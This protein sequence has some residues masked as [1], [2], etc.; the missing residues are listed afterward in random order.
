[1]GF[2]IARR[3][4]VEAF[5]MPR[6]MET[7][8]AAGIFLITCGRWEKPMTV[9]C[10]ECSDSYEVEPDAFGDGAMDYYVPFMTSVREDD[11]GP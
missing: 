8:P 3:F 6:K 4:F 1:M 9:A 11:D 7:K 10:V 5:S 2:F